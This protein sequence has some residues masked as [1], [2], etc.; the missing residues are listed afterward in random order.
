MSGMILICSF[1]ALLA[2]VGTR[3][4]NAFE[5]AR[6]SEW[7]QAGLAGADV[8]IAPDS[9]DFNQCVFNLYYTLRNE[10]NERNNWQRI[11]DHSRHDQGEYF[12]TKLVGPAPAGLQPVCAGDGKCELA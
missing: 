6:Q 12:G 11:G 10:E 4:A 1:T 2:T 8:G 3:S 5:S 7:A 9:G